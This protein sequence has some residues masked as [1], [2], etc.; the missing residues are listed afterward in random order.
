MQT[1]VQL[2]TAIAR[3]ESWQRAMVYADRDRDSLQGVY[4]GQ[5]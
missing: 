2:Q 1:D 4:H 5:R 3:F